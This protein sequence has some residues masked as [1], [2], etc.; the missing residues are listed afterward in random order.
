MVFHIIVAILT[1]FVMHA[2]TVAM[3]NGDRFRKDYLRT[4]FYTAWVAF[5][6]FML[7][8]RVGMDQGVQDALDGKYH[9]EVTVDSTLVRIPE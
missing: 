9:Y 4:F 1:I 7:G 8:F 2:L 3:V 5:M 6:L